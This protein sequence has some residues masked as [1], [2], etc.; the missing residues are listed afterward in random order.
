MEGSFFHFL[1]FVFLSR[2]HKVKFYK[3]CLVVEKDHSLPFSPLSLSSLSR[4]KNQGFLLGVGLWGTNSFPPPPCSL[5]P[6]PPLSSLPFSFFF[7]PLSL[8][9]SKIFFSLSTRCR[10]TSPT[11]SP[12]WFFRSTVGYHCWCNRLCLM[13]RFWSWGYGRRGSCGSPPIHS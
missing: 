5:P 8:T 2:Y 4:F 6:S 11:L 3:S 9:F 10:S 7:F 12:L 13:A 1:G